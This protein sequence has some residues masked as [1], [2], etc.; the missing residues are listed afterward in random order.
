M[1][2]WYRDTALGDV[3]HVTGQMT[4]LPSYG[5]KGGL[6]I[7]DSH[8]DPLRRTGEAAEKD[9]SV[10]EQPAQPPA[11]VERGVRP[12]ADVPV[13]RSAWRRRTSRTASTARSSRRRRR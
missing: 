11:V 10:T 6:L 4:A 3:N 8:F 2:V 12:P 7:V 9:P 5:A 13:Q 1:L